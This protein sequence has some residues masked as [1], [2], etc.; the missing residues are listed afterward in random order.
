MFTEVHDKILITKGLWAE[1]RVESLGFKTWAQAVLFT[2]R[3][4]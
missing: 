1:M 3:P 4:W 2:I